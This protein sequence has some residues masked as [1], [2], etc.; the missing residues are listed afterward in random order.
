MRI[1]SNTLLWNGARP[2]P[3]QLHTLRPSLSAVLDALPGAFMVFDHSLS[4]VEINQ[5]AARLFKAS[6]LQLLEQPLN[7]RFDEA[8]LHELAALI[9]VSQNDD[10]ELGLRL[11]A[12]Q[13]NTERVPV[14]LS[15]HRL[16]DEQP[17]CWL[18][19]LHELQRTTRYREPSFNSR[20]KDKRYGRWPLQRRF[21]DHRQRAVFSAIGLGTVDGENPDICEHTEDLQYLRDA[22]EQMHKLFCAFF[23]STASGVLLF[24]LDGHIQAANHSFCHM[25]GYSEAELRNMHQTELTFEEDRRHELEQLQTLQASS[26]PALQLEKRYRH[27]DGRAIWTLM[28]VAL[29]R[30]SDGRPDYFLATVQNINTLKSH[31]AKLE[32]NQRELASLTDHNPDAIG[33][34]DVRMRC[35]FANPAMMYLINTA[36]PHPGKCLAE[37]GFSVAGQQRW[38]EAFDTA[39]L[40]HRRH[41]FE[42]EFNNEGDIRTFLVK[43]VP[44]GN[45]RG[46][47]TTVL[48]I[49]RDVSSLKAKEHALQLREFELRAS[50]ETIRKLAAYNEK[51]RD[52]ERKRMAREIHDEL[53]QRLTA[54]KMETSVAQ[55]HAGQKQAQA[56]TEALAQIAASI[57]E[58]V[59]LVRNVATNL[60]PAAL[61]LGVQPAIEWLAEQFSHQHR[62]A[63]RVDLPAVDV[64]LD[65]AR[66]AIVFRIVQESLTNVARHAQANQVLVSL[67]VTGQGELRLT[68]ADNGCGFTLGECPPGQGFGLLSIRER[69]LILGGEL[70]LETH[71]GA[72]TRLTV[73]FP[74]EGSKSS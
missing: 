21:D 30:E 38:Q 45:S 48:A 49:A 67:E 19:E 41:T 62:I 57:E 43:V 17:G 44:E 54:L 69:S 10:L 71:P 16:H 56:L 61:N 32:R 39:F 28:S 36:S 34:F 18:A 72:G 15:L 74:I 24:R 8:D 51:V 46:E 3:G 20:A 27:R 4:I 40:F 58:T 66:A 2:A 37:L 33:R 63:C 25:L 22:L 26:T 53:G 12:I 65:D 47:V 13:K 52:E 70:N 31:E 14:W 35:I 59:Q 73:T 60:R 55:Y 11:A 6:R 42:F 5:R 68:V 50:Q 64:A 7:C 29:L 23:Q 9:D 1:E